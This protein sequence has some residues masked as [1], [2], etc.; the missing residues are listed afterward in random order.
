MF[1]RVSSLIVAI[2]MVLMTVTGAFAAPEF[3]S[4]KNGD[5]KIETLKNMG[6]ITGYEDGSL[7]LEQSIKRSEFS[8]LI[9][10]ALEKTDAANEI[11]GKFKPFNDVELKYWANGIISI[12]KAATGLNNEVNIIGGYPDGTFKPENNITNAEAI[13]MLV[14][15]KKADLT[16]EMAKN[17]EWPVSWIKWAAELGIIGE[18]SDVSS[19]LDMNAY[20][21]RGDVFKMFFN[22]F[23]V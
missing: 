3:T 1:K 2:A 16:K 6:F 4:G 23:E 5:E 17:A 15:L 19:M 14:V 8:K 20:A 10:E 12:V 9:V 22:T 13:K 18:G 11:N 21:T 7:K